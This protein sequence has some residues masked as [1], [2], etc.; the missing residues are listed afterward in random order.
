[1]HDEQDIYDNT[2]ASEILFRARTNTL[3]LGIKRKHQDGDIICELCKNG[4]EDLQHFLLRCTSLNSLSATG[5][6]GRQP[7]S[8]HPYERRS[9]STQ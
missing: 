9:E 7:P 2:A 5:D 3:L 6:T 4:R 1:M 8:F